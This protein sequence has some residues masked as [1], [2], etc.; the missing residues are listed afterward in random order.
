MAHRVKVSFPLGVGGDQ[1]KAKKE[2]EYET[3]DF[4]NTESD[5]QWKSVESYLSN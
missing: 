4:V 5:L 2:S 1:N 3:F